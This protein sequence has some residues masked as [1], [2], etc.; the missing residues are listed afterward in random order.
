MSKYKR[1]VFLYS[2]NIFVI[3]LTLWYLKDVAKQE[4]SDNY[5]LSGDIFQSWILDFWP[6]P[7]WTE[8]SKLQLYPI[9]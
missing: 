3:V 6:W 2:V 8:V 5:T 4:E 1:D 7:A 9:P